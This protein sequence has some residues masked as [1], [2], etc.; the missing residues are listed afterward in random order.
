MEALLPGGIVYGTNVLIEFEPDSLWQEASVTL[1][2]QALRKAVKT[3][4]HTFMWYPQK[5]RDA[6]AKL[7]LEIEKLEKDNLL[8]IFDSY[9]AQTGMV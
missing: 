8:R 1:A 4:Y 7:G 6:F 9:S 2:A 3:E 5:I